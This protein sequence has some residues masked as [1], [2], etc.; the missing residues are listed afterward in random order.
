[1]F[2]FFV[3][4]ALALSP[5][6]ADAAEALTLTASNV[7]IV[8]EPKAGG[9][10]DYA[11][12]ELGKWLGRALGAEIPRVAQPTGARVSLVLGDGALARAAGVD[13]SSLKRDGF[14]IRTAPGRIYIAGYDEKGFNLRRVM[15]TTG[16]APLDRHAHATVF[17]VYEFLE[18]FAGVRFYF[19]HDELGVVVPRRTSISVPPTDLTVEPANLIR[20]IYWGPDSVWLDGD[21]KSKEKDRAFG[22]GW[23][24][25]RLGTYVIPCCHGQN[26]F[27]YTERFS[28]TH[29]EY[30]QMRKDGSRCIETE[31]D[32]GKV[33]GQARQLC[34]SSA[35]WD[36]MYAD[37]KAYLT[38]Q[39]AESRGIR[40]VR[41]PE[42][43][44]WNGNCLD[45]RYVDI[46][47]QDG[48]MRCF[49]PKCQ[50]A[51]EDKP[52]FADRLIWGNTKRLAERL[53]AEGVPGYVTQMAYNPYREPPAFDLPT[54]ILVMVAENG[55]W[56][57]GNPKLFSRDRGRI[58][59]W[60]KKVGGNVWV[61]TYPGKWGR[62]ARP[63]VPA[64]GPRAYATFFKSVAGSIFGAFAESE[65]DRAIYNYLNHYVFGRVMWNPDV[66]VDALLD[67]HYRLMFGAAAPEMKAFYEGLEDLWIGEMVSRKNRGTS[68]YEMPPDLE[69]WQKVYSPEV[70]RRWTALFE[71]GAA[72]L[73]EGS[74]EAKR[75]AFIRSQFLEPLKAESAKFLTEISPETELA[76]RRSRPN[77]SI[78]VNGD[79]DGLDRWE[80]SGVFDTTTSV[81]GKGSLRLSTASNRV[82]CIQKLGLK[83]ERN[84]SYRIS[85][86][87]KQT[88]LAPNASAIAVLS[89]YGAD[90]YA[91]I[92]R[93][94]PRIA[95]RE[96]HDWIFRS[97][98]ARTGSQP[99]KDEKSSFGFFLTGAGT[100]WFDDVR[101]EKVEEKKAK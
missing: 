42:V 65:S 83:L 48:M 32:E 33:D 54:N 95:P 7:E 62:F 34:H 14:R 88:D 92:W 75:L 72:R 67:E 51:Y 41:N 43:F 93:T 82:V 55:P 63:G 4:A 80:G 56:S 90:S 5:A 50:A 27:R 3:L 25:Y 97:Y 70:L 37:V 57:V 26:G 66:D 2:V 11:A 36:E 13:V 29:P 73:A 77:T 39:S 1:M 86:F 24:R 52:E 22:L 17:G 85:Y 8:V 79:I 44:G 101:V 99:D 30:F 23:L 49:C 84:T 64:M 94:H 100:A 10:V 98:I 76:R 71:N 53:I 9:S 60:A 31:V 19:P 89:D 15:E 35:V 40:R 38:G 58:E 28:K 6:A 59:A 45:G 87:M 91:R 96:A 47:P 21:P 61:W 74:D 12:D 46:M 16:F 81:T 69:Q 20:T 18:R 78:L 68:F